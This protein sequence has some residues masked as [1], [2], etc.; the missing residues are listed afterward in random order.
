VLCE[1]WSRNC[2]NEKEDIETTWLVK[3]HATETREI[4]LVEGVKGTPG[5]AAKRHTQLKLIFL[6]KMVIGFCLQIGTLSHDLGRRNTCRCR[7]I[8]MI[9]IFP[10][11]FSAE[12][13]D[14]REIGPN[15]G[16][17]RRG[18]MASNTAC[19]HSNE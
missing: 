13:V 2:D 3:G 15:C 16:L 1:Q 17:L 6:I 8:K 11:V 19:L 14:R 12:M 5:H 10:N 7:P 9:E 18:F 4:V